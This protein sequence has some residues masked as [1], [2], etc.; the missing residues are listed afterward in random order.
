MFLE[1]KWDSKGGRKPWP[2]TT[3]V[4]AEYCAEVYKDELHIFGGNNGFESV[5]VNL[6]MSLNLRTLRW[7]KLG[8]TVALKQLIRG[9]PSMRKGAGSWVV[10]EERRMY[11]LYGC[12][13]PEYSRV[14]KLNGTE[15][16]Q[17]DMWS[18]SFE[19]KVWR[20]ERFRGNYPSP[21]ARFACAYNKKLQQVVVFGGGHVQLPSLDQH[22][23]QVNIDETPLGDTFILDLKSGIWKQIL[24][25]NFPHHRLKTQALFDEDTGKV[26]LFGGN[27]AFL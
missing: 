26:Y 25:R 10:P 13:T 27:C 6:H 7:S 9:M 5:G 15:F 21:R 1:T 8:G 20:R 17:D 24:T 14:P 18:Y 16:Q 22:Y 12:A 23:S 4:A 11:I 2:Y 3:G 19:E